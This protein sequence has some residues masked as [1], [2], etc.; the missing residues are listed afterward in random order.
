MRDEGSES[1]KPS[2]RIPLPLPSYSAMWAEWVIGTLSIVQ[3]VERTDYSKVTPEH[4][5][6]RKLLVQALFHIQN[7]YDTI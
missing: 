4:E 2:L 3:H 1:L 7:G 5:V 6:R